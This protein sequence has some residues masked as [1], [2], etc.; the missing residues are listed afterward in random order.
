MFKDYLILSRDMA[1]SKKDIVVPYIHISISDIFASK[2]K[3]P[4]NPN[5]LDA[6]EVKFGDINKRNKNVELSLS[7]ILPFVEKYK[8]QIELLVINCHYGVSRSPGIMAGLCEVYG[9][10]DKD[11]YFGFTGQ[12]Q[13]YPNEICR[14][15]IISLANSK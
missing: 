2:I 11:C 5:R 3:L 7:K 12:N 1:K 15:Y 13:R 9:L 6:F 8:D 14:D 10:D 4:E